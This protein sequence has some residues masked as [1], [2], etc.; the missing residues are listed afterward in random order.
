M[1]FVSVR[2]DIGKQAS[3]QSITRAKTAA[4]LPF[5]IYACIFCI[6]PSTHRAPRGGKVQ[7]HQVLALEGRRRR[8]LARA[9]GVANQFLAQQGLHGIRVDFLDFYHCTVAFCCVELVELLVVCRR[10]IGKNERP[11]LLSFVCLAPFS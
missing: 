3:K 10:V 4:L 2:K 9:P 6:H 11:F 1:D 8:Q 7:E 5:Q